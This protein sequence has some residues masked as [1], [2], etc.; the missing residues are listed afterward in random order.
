MTISVEP[1]SSVSQSTSDLVRATVAEVC[2]PDSYRLDDGRLARRSSSCLLQA[3]KQDQVLVWE[4][5]EGA[6]YI[7]SILVRP[8]GS[9]A[10]LSVPGADELTLDA[11]RVCLQAE[12]LI[13]LISMQ[14]LELC[15]SAGQLSAVAST[16]N[17]TALDHLIQSAAQCLGQYENLLLEAKGLARLHAQQMLLSA[18]Q[19]LRADAQ[20]I[21]MG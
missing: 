21:S 5:D 12:S 11:P 18:Q 8:T 15:A 13:R 7:L 19:D 9:T 20:R 4:G 1:L 2:G 16:I 14:N 10:R 6:C 17:L 3:Q